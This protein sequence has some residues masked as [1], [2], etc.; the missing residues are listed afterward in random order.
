M[1]VTVGRY[2]WIPVMTGGWTPCRRRDG[3]QLG[4]G[5]AR[6]HTDDR[7]PRHQGSRHYVRAADTAPFGDGPLR[8]R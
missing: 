7:E 5:A 4:E 8:F 2:S 6:T 3:Q 1:I